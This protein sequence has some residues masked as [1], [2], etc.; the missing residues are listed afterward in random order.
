MDE[1]EKDN[2]ANVDNGESNGYSVVNLDDNIGNDDIIQIDDN[3]EYDQ[4]YMTNVS[5]NLVSEVDKVLS[6]ALLDF[7]FDTDSENKESEEL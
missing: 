1:R 6:K 2:L 5:N 4:E 7:Q 3:D